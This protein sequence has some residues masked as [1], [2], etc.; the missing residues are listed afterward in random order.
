MVGR[1]TSRSPVRRALALSAVVALITALLPLAAAPAAA[2]PDP[3]GRGRPSVELI[4]PTAA[5]PVTTAAGLPLEVSF[6]ANRSWPYAV[7][8][9]A[10]G[11]DEW[12]TFGDEAAEGTAER[13]DNT[14]ELTVP[15]DVAAGDHDLR[16]RLFAPGPAR[17]E[18]SSDVAEAAL[19]VV[20]P[21]TTGFEDRDGAD[22]TTYSEE[23]EFLAELADASPRVTYS[24]IGE[25]N[26]GRPL[27]VVR[28]G[29]PEPPSD[30]DIAEGDSIMIVGSQHGNEPAGREMA[31][32][33]PR[34]LAFT[35]DAELLDQLS[36]TTVLFVPNANPDG[37]VA[38]TRGNAQGAD[39]NRDHLHFDTPEV[40]AITQT[41][42]DLDPEIVVDAHER[43]GGSNPDIELL[44]PRN[45]NVDEELR[46]LNRE[47]VEDYLFPG[48][49]D[50]GFSTGL[51]GSPGGAGGEDER[52]S[53]N[54]FGL[55]HKI[56][57]L[58]ETAGQDPPTYR[59][60][61]QLVT[62]EE[63]L[64]FHRERVDDVTTQ[65]SEAP[66]RRAA[67]GEAREAF[68]FGGA[69]NWDPDPD[70]IVDPAPCGYLINTAQS[71][72]VDRQAD[73]FGFER[74]QVSEQGVFVTMAQPMMTVVPLLLDAR[75]D[76]NL[77]EGNPLDDCSDPGSQ[78]PPEPPPEPTPPAQFSTDFS[79]DEVGEPPADWTTLWRDS[80]WTVLDDPRRLRHEVD[81][82][83][84]RRALTWDEVGDDGHVQGDVEISGLVRPQNSG[85][86][87]FQVGF[88]YGGDTN[89]ENAYYLDARAP[90]A[91]SAANHVRISRYNNGSYSTLGSVELPFTLTDDTWY[92]TVIQR[93]GDTLRVKL[94]PDGEEEPDWQASTVDRAH[95]GGRVGVSQFTS[96]VINDWAFIGVG[97]GGEPAPRAPA[98]LVP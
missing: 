13:G 47:M 69:D 23:L 2:Q 42:K 40:Q 54:A 84:G 36:D 72:A 33:F 71:S 60:E 28:V 97:T 21:P 66:E 86:T 98:D 75:A 16:V 35:A 7:D 85:D 39:I 95:D 5:A 49:E 62:M 26:E 41:V 96:G 70:E 91:S 30:E 10:S 77:V 37:R 87:M 94:W 14:I 74:E 67:D 52:I 68:Y 79:D 3:R 51:Y 22:W 80:G 25:S 12:E 55:R 1:P 45:L 56:G 82:A 44:W 50:A 18:L 64:A 31:L 93:D 63:L 58:T 89:D 48:L 19:D 61:A 73:L 6:E 29:Y 90:D 43:P 9:S 88:H 78:D 65:A 59:V 46:A 8:L 11:S 81:S 34:D 83:G 53:R 38:N 4:S 76:F 27:H 17:V 20:E 32:Q 92:R 24:E 57:L 15:G